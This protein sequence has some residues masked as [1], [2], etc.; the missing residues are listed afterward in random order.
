VTQVPTTVVMH[1]SRSVGEVTCDIDNS[2]R[3]LLPNIDVSVTIVT[4]KHDNVVMA[5]REAIHQSDGKRYVLEVQGDRL[6]RRDVETSISNLTD[7]EI[8][9]GVSPGA[10]LGLG[11]YNNQALHEGM[12][13]STQ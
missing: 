5:P 9:S 8:T 10:K 3:K 12:K 6:V 2:D 1:G 13:V 4:T 11:A 7:V